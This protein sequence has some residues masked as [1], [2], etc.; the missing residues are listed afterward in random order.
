ML[1]T[2]H[3]WAKMVEVNCGRLSKVKIAR[4]PKR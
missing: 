2:L 4:N 3:S 1:R